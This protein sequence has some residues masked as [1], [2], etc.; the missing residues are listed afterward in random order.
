MRGSSDLLA[1]TCT[2]YQ[3]CLSGLFKRSYKQS[4]APS[5]S[6]PNFIVLFEYN[7][8]SADYPRRGF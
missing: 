8:A 4:P 6:T 1:F 5:Q 7:N 2:P 3:A